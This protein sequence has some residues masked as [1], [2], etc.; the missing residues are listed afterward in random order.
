M[1]T[2]SYKITFDPGAAIVSGA[3][4][5]NELERL[6]LHGMR[7]LTDNEAER[8]LEGTLERFS[9]KIEVAYA[10]GLIDADLLDDLRV[11]KKIRDKFAH[12]RDLGWLHFESEKIIEI[13]RGFKGWNKDQ[14]KK[15]G[16]FFDKKVQYCIDQIEV[17]VQQLIW[18][19][20]NPEAN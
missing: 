11:L 14:E 16:S 9:T 12:P 10:F 19:H 2:P 17:K 18:E 7:K 6:L 3:R 20:A 15:P 1:P 8:L 13:M 4:V 5:E